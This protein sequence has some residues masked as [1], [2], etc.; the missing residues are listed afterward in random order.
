MAIYLINIVLILGLGAL[1][2]DMYKG[3]VGKRLYFA[4]I[5]LQIAVIT[6]LRGYSVGPDTRGYAWHFTKTAVKKLNDILYG[7]VEMERAYLLL[8]YG[9]SRIWDNP[10]F[11]FALIAIFYSYSVA[12]F[13]YKNSSEPCLSYVLFVTLGF[14]TF[15]MTGMRQT[16][17]LGI[18]LFAIDHIRSRSLIRFLI[19]VG[20][21]SLFHA[22][23]LVFVP[24]YFL[25][26]RK[27]TKAYI[28][29]ASLAIPASYLLRG[30]AFSLLGRLSGYEYDPYSS[31]GPLV[32]IA[33]MLIILVGS[34]IQ[35]ETVLKRSSDNII[36]YNMLLISIL[37]AMIAF[38]NPSVL[39]AAYYYHV[40]LL[41]FIPEVV[42]SIEDSKLRRLIYALAVIGLIVLDIRALSGGGV[43][44]PYSFFWQ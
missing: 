13:I 41:L 26:Y 34:F 4:I 9:V 11:F 8:E 2:L 36:Y 33:L 38:V 32:L 16:L 19:V 10:S 12:R 37:V 31:E 25:A 40:Y 27:I 28:L 14:F 15:S 42:L 20:I 43:F 21:A 3:Q 29:L 22:S 23:A 5:A 44:V 35:R 24:A 17:A 39:R 6:G 30:T 1:L 18:M 7:E